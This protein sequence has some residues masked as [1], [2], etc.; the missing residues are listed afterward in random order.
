MLGKPRVPVGIV[1]CRA[2]V[3]PVPKYGKMFAVTSFARCREIEETAVERYRGVVYVQR[4]CVTAQGGATVHVCH[5]V[6]PSM[7]SQ[8]GERDGKSTARGD[9]AGRNASRPVPRASAAITERGTAQRYRITV[10]ASAHS[11][12]GDYTAVTMALRAKMFATVRTRVNVV[13]VERRVEG[14]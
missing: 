13:A 6:F 12:A 11:E 14:A 9:E 2:R 1:E 4:P 10:V 3:V 5:P 7:L 8:T